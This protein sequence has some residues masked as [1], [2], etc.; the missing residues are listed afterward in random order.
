MY[1]INQLHSKQANNNIQDYIFDGLIDI[2]A[3]Q[4]E[5]QYS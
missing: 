4:S 2:M 3:T 5:V 1:L